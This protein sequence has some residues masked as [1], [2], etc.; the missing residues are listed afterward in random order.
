ME[1]IPISKR[2]LFAIYIVSLLLKHMPIN[3]IF[4]LPIAFFSPSTEPVI[5]K[6]LALFLTSHFEQ[7]IVQ[8]LVRTDFG[9]KN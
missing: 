9:D 3:M 6:Q 1:K 5:R 8:R 4:T 7:K 2:F